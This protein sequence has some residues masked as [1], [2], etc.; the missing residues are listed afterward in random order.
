MV[1]Q[2]ASCEINIIKKNKRLRM[3]LT[4]GYD[5]QQAGFFKKGFQVN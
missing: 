3:L 4:C 2:E 5:L 1:L